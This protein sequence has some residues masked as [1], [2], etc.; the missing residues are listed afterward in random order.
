[1]RHSLEIISFNYGNICQ[2]QLKLGSYESEQLLLELL[3]DFPSIIFLQ[4]PALIQAII[5]VVGS[6]VVYY[7]NGN[8][9][10]ETYF[11]QILNRLLLLIKERCVIL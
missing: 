1:M 9:N 2:V 4:K 3:G 5:D 6:S 10:S 8:S 11:T 7:D